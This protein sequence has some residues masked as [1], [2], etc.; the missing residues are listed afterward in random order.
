MQIG[1]L[2]S[3]GTVMAVLGATGLVLAMFAIVIGVLR[4]EEPRHV[5]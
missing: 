4:G 1:S 3:L 2:T 5:P